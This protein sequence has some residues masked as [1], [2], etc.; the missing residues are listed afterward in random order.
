[1]FLS[2]WF[3]RDARGVIERKRSTRHFRPAV[4]LLEDRV[5]PSH[6]G[7][8]GS[9]PTPGPATH[10]VVEVPENVKA[11]IPFNVLVEA[12]DAS[13]H[14]ATGYTGTVTFSLGTTDSGATLPANYTFTTGRG[15]DNG[16]HVFQVTLAGTNATLP[17]SQTITVTDTT[18]ATIT[19][20]GTTTVNPAPVATQLIVHVPNQVTIGVPTTVTVVA[21]DASGHVVPN[22]TGTVSL[23][24]PTDSLSTLPS[25][26][27]FSSTDAGRYTFQVV[28]GTGGSQAVVATDTATPPLTGKATTTVKTVG[29]VT[30][31]GVLTLGFALAG[32]PTQ[33]EVVALDANNRVVAGYTGIVHF[34][35]SDTVSGVILPADYT[36]VAGDYGSHIFNATLI[37]P[38]SQSITATDTT[39]ASITGT[40]KLRVLPGFPSHGFFG[41]WGD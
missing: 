22:Y 16:L 32:F 6:F 15:G 8:F 20:S 17:A 13:N 11:D 39:T 14:T 35:S 41:G 5:T 10:L 27:T 30:H 40:A 4:C 23:T 3:R 34:T 9:P 21:E 33:F 24:T 1:M 28:F 31:F 26:H 2:Q 29:A 38:G 37:S 7:G 19:G 36:F 25:S 18:T 12:E